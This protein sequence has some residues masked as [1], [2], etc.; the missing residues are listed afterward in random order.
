MSTYMLKNS[1]SAGAIP[2]YESSDGKIDSSAVMAFTITNNSYEFYYN[3]QGDFPYVKAATQSSGSSNIYVGYGRDPRWTVGSS[4]EG[5]I[6]GPNPL[7]LCA[8]RSK[9]TDTSTTP[10][11]EI[12]RLD[13]RTYP[14]SV[15]DFVDRWNNNQL[16][17][18][19]WLYR[20]NWADSSDLY[21]EVRDWDET[22]STD[23]EGDPFNELPQGG[24]FAELGAWDE[25]V[26]QFIDD[27]LEPET[28]DY[29]HFLTAYQLDSDNLVD[30]GDFLFDTSFW[31]ALKN[32]FE[33]L[34]DPL[35][36]IVSAVEIPF[37][38]G[39]VPTTFKLGGVEVT[40]SG[41]NPIACAKHTQRYLKYTFGN[42][43]LSEV[44]G[45][46]KDYTDCDISIFLPYVGM[47]RIDPDLGVNSVLRLAA[48]IDVWTG[49]LNYM[50]EVNNNSMQNKYYGSSGVPYRWSG[51]CGNKI[52]IGKVDPS[53]PILNVAASL[54]S[55]A[56]GAGL[57]MA[58]GPGAA[59]AGGMAS[60]AAGAGAGGAVSAGAGAGMLLSGA[61][62]FMHD[63]N[64]GFN[65]IA[66]SSGNISGAIGFMDFQYPYLVIKRGIPSY[67]NN[68][69]QEIGAP[70]Y[71]EFQVSSLSGYTEF[72]EIHADAVNGA[73]DDEK[74]M[75]EDM[76]KA[77][78][79]L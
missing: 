54:G 14:L 39:V 45:T 30:I 22:P 15:A 59:A 71:Q 17:S 35:A 65:P 41:G 13:I 67:P 57:M 38:L 7:L 51:N 75:I 44:W 2:I 29:G 8:V 74:L 69:R 60:G 4:Q 25:T 49:D 10:P 63:L 21:E 56:I 48:I 40:G 12:D 43:K 61:K 52:P 26:Q 18:D 77:G 31:S 24:E 32:K 66:Q 62:G 28:L 11:T 19:G 64:N 73:S 16:T 70:R 3:Q 20:G 1:G 6:G 78:V 68:W 58:G 37:T 33:G 9:Y 5:L 42:I 72:A 53:T 55:M 50:L 34:S 47:R 36:M 79:I 27:L 23:K 46:A 76:L